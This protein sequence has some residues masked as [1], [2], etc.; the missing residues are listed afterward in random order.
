MNKLDKSISNLADLYEY[1]HLQATTAPAEFL[2]QV[3]DEIKQSRK[4]IN[5]VLIEL[6][7]ARNSTMSF[8]E[9]GFF[10]R[11]IKILE[12]DK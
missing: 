11:L 2:D 10:E 8:R 5:D 7:Q 9:M 3:A 1:G 4:K 6:N 12:D